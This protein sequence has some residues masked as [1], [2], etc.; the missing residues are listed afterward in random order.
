MYGDGLPTA[1]LVVWG[2]AVASSMGLT[3]RW[4]RRPREDA[5]SAVAC[6]GLAALPCAVLLADYGVAAWMTGPYLERLPIYSALFI[7]G[8]W[9]FAASCS[10]PAL[11]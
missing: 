10:S 11:R 8:S 3:V 1:W 4:F 2:A 5:T 9:P 7:L 6:T